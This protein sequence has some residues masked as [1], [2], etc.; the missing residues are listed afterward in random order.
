MFTA[1][2]ERIRHSHPII[3]TAPHSISTIE[4]R[5]NSFPEGLRP[6]LS[7]AASHTYISMP[8]DQLHTIQRYSRISALNCPI[9]DRSGGCTAQAHHAKS[10]FV[11][12]AKAFCVA[13]TLAFYSWWGSSTSRPLG[14]CSVATHPTF[15]PALTEQ[16]CKD[17]VRLEFG[18]FGLR[19]A[20]GTVIQ[21]QI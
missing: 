20:C 6:G 17:F 10:I 19:R 1:L 15:V 11:T 18:G 14:N 4:S 2:G 12:P 5:R 3:V 9:W 8:E 21:R 7:I 13:E 16:I